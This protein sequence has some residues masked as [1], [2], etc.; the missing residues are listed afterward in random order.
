MFENT[1]NKL[2]RGRDGPFLKSLLNN[3][4]IG[5]ELNSSYK[6]QWEL[7]EEDAMDGVV[8]KVT[9]SIFSSMFE[10]NLL[11]PEILDKLE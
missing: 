9:N 6:L 2:K 10:E 3:C 7:G 4:L 11:P 8:Y 5:A 1:E